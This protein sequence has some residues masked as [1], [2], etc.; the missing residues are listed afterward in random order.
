M[1]IVILNAFTYY[2][3]FK[4]YF[5]YVYMTSLNLSLLYL[6]FFYNPIPLFKII[7]SKVVCG[8]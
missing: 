3:R 5:F 2:E 6:Y 4:L 1:L 7:N 8:N